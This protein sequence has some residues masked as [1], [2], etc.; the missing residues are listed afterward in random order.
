MSPQTKCSLKKK[1]SLLKVPSGDVIDFEDTDDIL[2]T[3]VFTQEVEVG[4]KWDDVTSWFSKLKPGL[5]QLPNSDPQVGSE[6]ILGALRHMATSNISLPSK[7]ELNSSGLPMPEIEFS[8][9]VDG[10]W[11]I[12]LGPSSLCS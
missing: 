4:A 8:V 12:C 10:S 7:L 6:L 3:L 2:N 1:F 5:F 11:S 9:G